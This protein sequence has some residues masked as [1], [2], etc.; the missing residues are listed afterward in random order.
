MEALEKTVQQEVR[1]GPSET[2]SRGDLDLAQVR[3]RKS[4]L[5]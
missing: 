5:A 2:G 1:S 4:N 3:R